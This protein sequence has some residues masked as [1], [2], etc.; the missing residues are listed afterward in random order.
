MGEARCPLTRTVEIWD[1]TNGAFIDFNTG[2][3]TWANY[4]DDSASTSRVQFTV[5]T[6]D[7]ATLDNASIEETLY[8]MRI[9]TEDPYSND[10]T[11]P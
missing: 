11:N 9:T 2:T 10:T 8:H 5:D 7:W 4:V 1:D 6:E 3:H